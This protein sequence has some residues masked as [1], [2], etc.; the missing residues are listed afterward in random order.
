MGE[1]NT[2]ERFLKVPGAFVGEKF[3]GANGSVCMWSG[4]ESEVGEV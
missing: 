2:P 1:E 4:R 3:A